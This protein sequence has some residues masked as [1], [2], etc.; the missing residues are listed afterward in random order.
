MKR[1]Q[2]AVVNDSHTIVPIFI[3]VRASKP[4]DLMTFALRL[5]RRQLLARYY[6]FLLFR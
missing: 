4:E 5:L 1:I 3:G 2:Q 6:Y